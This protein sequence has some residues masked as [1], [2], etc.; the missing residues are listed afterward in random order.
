MSAPLVEV[1]GCLPN[2]IYPFEGLRRGVFLGGR[3]SVGCAAKV[4]YAHAND[5][6]GMVL[7]RGRCPVLLLGWGR[8]LWGGRGDLGPDAVHLVV[9]R[10]HAD[11]VTEKVVAVR[12]EGVARPGVVGE[13]AA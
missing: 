4:G 7:G 5:G 11:V 13:G 8:L 12:D 2:T 9:Q 6:L 1:A 3:R 10:G